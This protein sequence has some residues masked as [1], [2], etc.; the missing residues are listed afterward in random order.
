MTTCV[1]GCGRPT[2]DTLLLCRSCLWALECDLGDVG[3]LDEQLETVLARQIAL[4]ERNGGH[5][6]ETPLPVH[7]GAFKARSEL[8]VTL[9][10]WVRDMADTG[11]D[12]LPADTMPALAW[13]LL[14]R[15]DRIALHPAAADLHGEIVGAVRLAWRVVDAPANRTTFPVGP[16]PELTCAGE[17]RAYIPAQPEREARMECTECHRCW[18]P[19]Q[20]LRTGRRILAR[21]GERIAYVD[22]QVAAASLGVTDRTV[23]RWVEAGRLANHGDERRILVD[24]AEL[25]RVVEVA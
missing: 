7:P 17:V 1:T 2:R 8:R 19:T 22:V 23:R 16:C 24:M 25:E 12:T 14:K 15:I 4:S 13:W 11:G 9:V 20:W 18:D 21:K 6:A 3:W 10:G 5:S